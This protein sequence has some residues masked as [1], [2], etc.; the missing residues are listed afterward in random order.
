MK[1]YF[2]WYLTNLD[3]LQDICNTTYVRID[4]A[5]GE[6]SDGEPYW[7]ALDGFQA[8]VEEKWGAGHLDHKLDGAEN[9]IALNVTEYLLYQWLQ[10]AF[11]TSEYRIDTQLKFGVYSAS[12]G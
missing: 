8:T 7:T 11:K 10:P 6:D 1:Y 9:Y 2:D 4:I 3:L 12:T 5:I